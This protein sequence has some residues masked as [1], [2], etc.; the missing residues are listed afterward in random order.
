MKKESCLSAF[1]DEKPLK[2][3][4]NDTAEA[5]KTFWHGNCF[6]YVQLNVKKW[7]IQT[8]MKEN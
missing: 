3:S 7:T 4:K 1:R 5:P 8:M 2:S 6:K